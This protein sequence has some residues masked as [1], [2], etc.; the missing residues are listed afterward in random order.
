MDIL[1][2]VAAEINRRGLVATVEYPG[3]INVD[4]IAFGTANE[5]WGWNN[6]NATECGEFDIPSDST[7]VN[8]ITDAIVS[9]ITF[10]RNL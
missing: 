9:L 4:G 3:Y 2:K 7:D 1:S 5:T 6:E 10:G 8:A